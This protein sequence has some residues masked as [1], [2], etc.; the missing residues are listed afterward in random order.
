MLGVFITASPYDYV[1]R[2]EP[3]YEVTR[4]LLN[5]HIEF[6]ILPFR[7]GWSNHGST[8]FLHAFLQFGNNKDISFGF[9][10]EVF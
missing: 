7:S 1:N 6:P 3:S 10:N 9:E 5:F 8:V 2:H 4:R